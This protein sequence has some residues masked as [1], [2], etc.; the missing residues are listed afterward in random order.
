[1]YPFLKT[2]DWK[3]IYKI[4]FNVIREPYLQSFQYKVINRILNTIY[5]E[6]KEIPVITVRK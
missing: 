5:M 2:I 3:D 4:S 1:M 6:S